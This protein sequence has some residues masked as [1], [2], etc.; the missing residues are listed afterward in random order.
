M[1]GSLNNCYIELRSN[2]GSSLGRV[3]ISDVIANALR[4]Y[5]GFGWGTSDVESSTEGYRTYSSYGSVGSLGLFTVNSKSH[6]SA[7]YSVAGTRLHPVDFCDYSQT[8]YPSSN[9]NP[10]LGIA[11]IRAVHY[12]STMSGTWY[13]L[14]GYGNFTNNYAWFVIAVRVY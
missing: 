1:Y 12:G 2:S 13:V 10:D 9:T 8:S 7:G 6:L 3:Y 4:G 14:N 11:D 5:G